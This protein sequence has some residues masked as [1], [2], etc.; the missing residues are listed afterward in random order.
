LSQKPIGYGKFPIQQVEY[1][2]NVFNNEAKEFYKECGCEIL[3]PALETSN[4]IKSGIELM[5]CKHCLRFAAGLCG[6]SVKKLYLIDEKG[7]KYPLKFD[8]KNCE[9]IILSP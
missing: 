2:A 6:K 8:C 7:K 1:H 9:M 5:R 4:N 3:E